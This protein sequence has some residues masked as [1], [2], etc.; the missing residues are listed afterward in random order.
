MIMK[1]VLAIIAVAA[2]LM[3]ALNVDAQTSSKKKKTTSKTTKTTATSTTAATGTSTATKAAT[4]TSTK[5]SSLASGVSSIL[6]LTNTDY[7]NGLKDALKIAA[8][9]SADAASMVDGFNKNMDIR[10]PFPKDAI[11]VKDYAVKVGLQ[12]QVDLFEEMLN[13]A[14]EEAA[15]KAAP[16]FLS[17]IVN[18]SFTDAAKIVTGDK[19]AAT[20]Y[21]RN[22]AGVELANQ[23]KPVVVDAL[24]QVAI[25]KYWK[26]LVDKYNKVAPFL[27]K[28]PV[29]ADLNQ[30]VT[31]KA[32]DGLFILVEKEEAKIRQEPAKYGSDLV[33]KIFGTK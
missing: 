20:V 15:K 25:T 2:L 27:L 19:N 24:S 12:S 23:F 3:P 32:V 1:R 17:A 14:A 21:L 6:S 29:Q 28:E 31:D 9:K 10:I 30:Y 33:K 16:I 11:A 8:T 13:R 5:T 7:S 18:M 26:P 4:A 22:T